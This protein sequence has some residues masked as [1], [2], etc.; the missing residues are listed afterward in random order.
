VFVIEEEK[1]EEEDLPNS[2]HLIFTCKVSRRAEKEGAG[3]S[4][5]SDFCQSSFFSP[6]AA[7]LAS[8][9][10]SQFSP[11]SHQHQSYY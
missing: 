2:R 3:F 5:T 11:G 1:V 10:V 4:L 7:A 9:T 8:V 6:A